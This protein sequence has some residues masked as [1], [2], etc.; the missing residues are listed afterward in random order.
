MGFKLLF[1]IRG[2]KKQ[3]R[4]T[5]GVNEMS[6]LLNKSYYQ[7][8]PREGEGVEKAQNLVYVVFE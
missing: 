7:N 1:S 4:Q 6:M 3:H 2:I 5:G 8:C